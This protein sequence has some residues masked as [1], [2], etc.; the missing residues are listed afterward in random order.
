MRNA[1][2]LSMAA[3]LLLISGLSGISQANAALVFTDTTF[4]DS[5]WSLTTV[6]F[7]GGGAASVSQTVSG[8]NP[9]AYCAYT[10]TITPTVTQSA[11]VNVF[12]IRGDAIYYPATQGA[13]SSVAYAEDTFTKSL[14]WGNQIGAGLALRQDGILYYGGYRIDAGSSWTTHNYSSLTASDFLDVG[15]SLHPDFSSSASPITFGF[16]RANSE[17]AGHNWSAQVAGGT[18]NWQVTVTPVPE[19]ATLTILAIGL[20]SLAV[21]NRQQNH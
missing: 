5:E 21:R 7:G 1:Q 17:P 8:G 12:H 16:L 14:G 13:I 15:G 11:A 19:P 3:S 9:G 18:D 10:H 6:L 2:M 4:N 20:S